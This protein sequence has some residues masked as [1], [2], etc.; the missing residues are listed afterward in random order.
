MTITDFRAILKHLKRISNEKQKQT[1][2]AFEKAIIET[3]DKDLQRE[4][5]IKYDEITKTIIK[6]IVYFL[7]MSCIY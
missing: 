1:K 5:Q 6:E 3:N 2:A 4:L 7:Q